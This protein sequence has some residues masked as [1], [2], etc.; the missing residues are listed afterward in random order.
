MTMIARGWLILD[1]TDSPFMVTAINGVGM[2]PMLVFSAFGGVIADRMSRK[3]IL[4]VSDAFNLVVLL[5]LALL[6]ITDV[7][8]VWQVFLLT[9]LHGFSFAMGTPARAAT[10]GNILNPKDLPSGVALFTTIFS[11]AQLV[12]PA[13]AGY[14]INSF[15]M[16]IPFAVAC[17]LMIPAIALMSTLGMPKMAAGPGSGP[18][19]SVLQSIA[20]G[21]AYVKH[22]PILVG[23][24]L[25][26]LSATVFAMPYQVMLPVFA[27]D[28]LNVGPSGLGVMGG[29]AGAGAIIGSLSVAVFS[30]QS[31]LRY[32]ML[33]GGIGL[34]VTIVLFA[35]STIYAL[36]LLLL[37]LTG[38]LFQIFMTSNFTLVQLSAPDYIRG[39]V[40]SLR[41]IVLGVSPLGMF[42]LGAAAEAF[43]APRAT[44]VMAAISVLI[45]IAIMMAIPSLRRVEAQTEKPEPAPTPEPVAP[46]AVPSAVERQ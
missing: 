23:L 42:T 13:L 4:I 30:S 32:L 6:V 14:L 17:L 19:V 34:G 31:Q 46:T 7:I 12:G 28:I 8:Q 5:I 43:G 1:M 36:S 20:Q 25:L 15:G 26:G 35:L 40:L 24:L 3:L 27:R 39:R 22:S 38:F 41:M 9:I 11:S 21:V 29:V 44:A 18:P 10:V 37:L 33:G 16:G 45:A 2:L